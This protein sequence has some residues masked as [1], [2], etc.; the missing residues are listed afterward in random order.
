MVVAIVNFLSEYF[1]NNLA[2]ILH[3]EKKARAVIN[4]TPSY[5]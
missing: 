1:D 4:F 5:C 3:S 2:L